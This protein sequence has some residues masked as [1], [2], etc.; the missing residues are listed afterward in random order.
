MLT[1]A[2]VLGFVAAFAIPLVLIRVFS[3][4][5][6]GIY[7]QV[8]LI[9]TTA[10]QILALGIP[11]S[12]FYFLPRDEHDGH[13]YLVQ[14]IG[15]LSLAGVLG[16]MTV[17]VGGPLLANL[18]GAPG[19]LA[20]VPW[21]A[22]LILIE[23]PS[24]VV[25]TAP[26]ADQ[27][28]ILAGSVVAGSDILRA[29][30][31]VT[32]VLIFR[33]VGAVVAAAALI[34][35]L[36]IAF[37][38]FYMGIRRMDGSPGPS[39]ES[40]RKQ[41]SYALPFWT[42][43]LF[44]IGLRRT[45]AYY[46]MAAVPTAEF[47][48]YS[49]GIFQ[50][51]LVLHITNSVAEVMIVRASDAHERGDTKSLRETW[52][53]AT[54]RLSVILLPIWVG[55][56]VFAPDL[57]LLLFQEQ[58]LAAVPVFRIFVTLFLLLIVVDHGILRAT[59]DTGFMLR[60]NALGFVVMLVCLPLLALWDVQL[61]AVTAFILG[62]VATRVAGLYKVSKRV[63]LPMRRSLPWRTIMAA[64]GLSLVASGVGWLGGFWLDAVFLR[65]AVGGLLFGSTYL[66]L[67]Y[68]FSLVP[69]EEI[70]SLLAR[71]RRKRPGAA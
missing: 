71:F 33:T 3:Q 31:F 66:L 51:P 22:L 5:D 20:V 19:L 65:L 56:Q 25:Q 15:L 39:Y 2:R 54:A 58:Y 34:G 12:I 36:R 13:R 41:L 4:T 50:L 27:R 28:S 67:V 30:A 46:V 49:I 6:F 18:M 59:G 42:A 16:A 64:T 52:Q 23:V 14:A 7:K 17:L 48:V 57:F 47:A 8:F 26:I 45:H 69:R 53:M 55:T 1:G 44:Q 32:A 43:L 21:L 38:L 63:G 70:R 62:T 11:A 61:G 24:S 40:T 29:I 60:A 68:A 9:S 10:V 35:V 37:F